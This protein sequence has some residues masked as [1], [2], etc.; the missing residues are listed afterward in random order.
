MST[1]TH[2]SIT[3][4]DGDTRLGRRLIAAMS[5]GLALAAMAVVGCRSATTPAEP[6]ATAEAASAPRPDTALADSLAAKSSPPPSV[7]WYAES[8]AVAADAETRNALPPGSGSAAPAP[9]PDARL[10]LQTGRARAS[11]SLRRGAFGG[12]GGV[13]GSRDAAAEQASQVPV[14]R[15]PFD[16]VWVIARD[17][18]A[19]GAPQDDEIPGIGSLGCVVPDG[20]PIP[21]P[22]LASDYR[23]RVRG[24]IA[25]T[26]CT[27]RFR[28]TFSEA[29]EAIYVFPLPHRAAVAD[30]VLAVG[31]RRIR[32]IVRDRAEAEQIYREAKEAGFTASLLREDRP[33]VF[34]EKIA[35]LPP[36][37]PVDVELTWFEALGYDAGSHELVL[38]LV[39]APRWNACGASDAVLPAAAPIANAVANAA[40]DDATVVPYLPAGESGAHRVSISV[41]IDAGRGIALG[42]IESPTHAITVSRPRPRCPTPPEQLPAHLATVSL[43]EETS[44]PNR[45]FVLRWQVAGEAPRSSIVASRDAD[46]SASG[47]LLLTL[48]PPEQ[49]AELPRP[50]ID[51]AILLDRSGSMNGQPLA[52]AQ[53]AIAAILASLGPNDRVLLGSFSNDVVFAEPLLAPATPERVARLAQ[54]TQQVQAGGGT[55]LLTGLDAVLFGARELEDAGRRQALVI[56]TD[57]LSGDEGRIIKLAHDKRGVQEIHCLGIGDSTNRFLIDELARAGDGTS[58]IVLLGT[59]VDEQVHPVIGAM[60]TAAIVNP[61]IDFAAAGL[62]DVVPNRLPTLRPGRPIVIAGRWEGEGERELVVAGTVGTTAVEVPIA[63]TPPSVEESEASRRALA[64]VWARATIA[65]MSEVGRRGERLSTGETA[66]EGIRR[67]AIEH[68]LVS[69]LTSFVAVDA[70]EALP[71][72][73]TQTIRQAVPVPQGIDP[74]TT[75]PGASTPRVPPST[76]GPAD[77][78]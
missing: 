52:A 33:N 2:R 28:N 47:H 32:G 57:G 39:V 17:R 43:A 66:L 50:S 21:M 63:F 25:E 34:T 3:R 55:N 29:V 13:V 76:P 61:S 73:G 20:P 23:V 62:V 5:L 11:E 40:G 58:G 56:L 48:Y 45:D 8:A 68:G 6:V 38:P 14:I 51:L 30:F 49:A 7:A 1:S 74:S 67:V 70:S 24:P 37:V 15:G 22:L 27:Q 10:G 69:P 4:R 44:V 64:K 78:A 65:D 16:E 59:S 60:Q 53:Q 54:W 26:T 46:G 35:N 12:G 77:G 31:D 36:Q 19:I 72:P 18:D 75:I 9:S 42:S 41:E 71:Q